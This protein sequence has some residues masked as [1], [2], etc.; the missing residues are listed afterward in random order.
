MIS[1]WYNA[2]QIW[3]TAARHV[4]VVPL[5]CQ[6]AAVDDVWLPQTHLTTAFRALI[7]EI[8][9]EMVSDGLRLATLN[10][11]HGKWC[12][13][14]WVSGR[15][16]LPSEDRL[17]A[18]SRF[19]SSQWETALL[20]NDVSHWLDANI[21]S[22]LRLLATKTDDE[23]TETDTVR[24]QWRGNAVFVKFLYNTVN[25]HHKPLAEDIPSF[26]PGKVVEIKSCLEKA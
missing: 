2:T 21:E 16:S 24:A 3:P 26:R 7:G 14:S 19:A 8:T 12:K 5:L 25:F 1:I 22:A 9:W 15:A 17:R 13:V 18:N 4:A 10:R 20:C 11:L 6:Y 23:L